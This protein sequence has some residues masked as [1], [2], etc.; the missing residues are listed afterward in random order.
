ML[1]ASNNC[2]LSE[3]ENGVPKFVAYDVRTL[4]GKHRSSRRRAM[5]KLQALAVIK[6]VEVH[7]E[8]EIHGQYGAYFPGRSR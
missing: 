6:G 3:I 4:A 2:G 5:E 1:A 7:P 8:I